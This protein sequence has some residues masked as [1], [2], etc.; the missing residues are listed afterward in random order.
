MGRS[1]EFQDGDGVCYRVRFTVL[2]ET[3]GFRRYGIRAEIFRQGAFQE[4]TEAPGRF[5][6]CAEAEQTIEMLCRFQVTP[7][8]LCDVI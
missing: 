6:T 7:C 1:F 4:S 3:E 2:E 5:L 8:T